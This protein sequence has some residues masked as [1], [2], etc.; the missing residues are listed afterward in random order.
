M[1]DTLIFKK[2]T[3]GFY[4]RIRPVVKPTGRMEGAV[5][6]DTVGCLQIQKWKASE[7]KKEVCRKDIGK[8]MAQKWTKSPLKKNKWR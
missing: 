6:W 4:G 7:S 2:L 3:G 8:T 5:R 1:D